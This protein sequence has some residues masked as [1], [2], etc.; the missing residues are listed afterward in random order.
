MVKK[1][2]DS[3]II[4]LVTELVTLIFYQF[5]PYIRKSIHATSI[6]IYI[7]FRWNSSQLCNAT[8][9]HVHSPKIGEKI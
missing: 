8:K 4:W 7:F 5:Q 2:C 3:R 6:Y 1:L 9:R